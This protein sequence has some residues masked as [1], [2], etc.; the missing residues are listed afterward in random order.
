MY[1]KLKIWPCPFIP[2]HFAMLN[3]VSFRVVL[4]ALRLFG[5][6]LH[7]VTGRQ[8]RCSNHSRK[9]LLQSVQAC[10]FK[11]NKSLISRR[12][13]FMPYWIVIVYFYYSIAG[14]NLIMLVRSHKSRKNY[15]AFYT[16]SIGKKNIFRPYYNF[17]TVP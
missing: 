13:Q 3:S 12:K 7:F 6:S 15:P 2:L 5:S 4:C 9:K 11:I 8:S 16:F 17:A 14:F 1:I 10:S